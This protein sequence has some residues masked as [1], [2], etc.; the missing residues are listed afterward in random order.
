MFHILDK[1]QFGKTFLGLLLFSGVANCGFFRWYD[2]SMCARSKI[3]ILGLFKRIRDLELRSWETN[4]FEGND[5]SYTF[6]SAAVVNEEVS[7][8]GGIRRNWFCVICREKTIRKYI[9]L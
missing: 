8:E 4:G 6:V 5:R 3:I 2:P 7:F 1:F 9:T